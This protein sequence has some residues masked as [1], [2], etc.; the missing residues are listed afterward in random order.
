MTSGPVDCHVIKYT[1]PTTPGPYV[2]RQDVLSGCK[3]VLSMYDDQ[4][5]FDRQV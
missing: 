5:D 1:A 3:I 4:S 2:T